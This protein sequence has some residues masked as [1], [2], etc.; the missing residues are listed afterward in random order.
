MSTRENSVKHLANFYSVIA[1]LALTTAVSKLVSE[2]G[3][4][5]P[6]SG[7]TL[8]ICVAFIVTLLPFYHGALRHLDLTYVEVKDG[9]PEPKSG[10]FLADFVILFIESGFFIVLAALIRQPD[11]FLYV[12]LGLLLFD[13]AWGLIAYIAFTGHGK[14]HQELAWAKINFITSLVILA[15][16]Y[17]QSLISPLFGSAFWIFVI[18]LARTIV[19][20]WISWRQG[21]YSWRAS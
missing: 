17:S 20:Y 15:Y 3:D 21:Y 11:T 4:L 5:L 10:A 12:Y 18:A 7:Q 8:L 2:R 13:S 14:G 19:D 9:D 1:G 6:F 16:I